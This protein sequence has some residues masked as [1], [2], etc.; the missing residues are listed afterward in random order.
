MKQFLQVLLLGAVATGCIAAATTKQEKTDFKVASYNIGWWPEDAN[1]KRIE[2]VK[3]VIANLKAEVIAMQE[4]Q[5]RASLNQ[6]FNDEWQ[7][8]IADEP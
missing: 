2:N 5:S 6:I 7:I 4:I 1:P 3:S 8:G